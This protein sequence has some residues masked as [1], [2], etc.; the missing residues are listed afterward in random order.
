MKRNLLTFTLILLATAT[1]SAGNSSTC[2]KQDRS[3]R[4]SRPAKVVAANALKLKQS[5]QK[6]KP[7]KGVKNAERQTG[8]G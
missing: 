8:E 7:S 2:T 4:H 3:D 5:I 1:A 6:Q